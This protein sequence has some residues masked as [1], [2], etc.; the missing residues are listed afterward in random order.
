MPMSS[1]RFAR[2]LGSASGGPCLQRIPAGHFP[3]SCRCTRASADPARGSCLDQA[4]AASFSPT[5]GD[6]AL[7][8]WSIGW[9]TSHGLLYGDERRHCLIC[10][11]PQL[12]LQAPELCS[13]VFMATSCAGVPSS[14]SRGPCHCSVIFL[15]EGC[16]L[17]S[18]PRREVSGCTP[19][20]LFGH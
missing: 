12:L 16:L 2:F 18:Y 3:T 6:F 8:T 14:S 9:A 19:C 13:L 11:A 1:L 15:V 17:R 20:C 5:V 4:Y 7:R 10:R